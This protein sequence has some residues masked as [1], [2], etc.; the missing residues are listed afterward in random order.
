MELKIKFCPSKINDKAVKAAK[1]KILEALC[2]ILNSSKEG[3]KLIV[4]SENCPYSKK[5]A[6]VI[7]RKIE[8]KSKTFGVVLTREIIDKLPQ[9]ND[10]EV[11][12]IHYRIKPT[13]MLPSKLYTVNCNLYCTTITEVTHIP[14]SE[15]F[16]HI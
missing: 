6:D 13:T 1:P 9:T 14:S 3:G 12:E 8:Q 15:P 7:S 4:F 10:G 2:A 5:S 16:E 11:F